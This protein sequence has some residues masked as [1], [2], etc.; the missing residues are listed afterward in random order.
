MAE[1][2]PARR[3]G[4]PVWSGARRLREPDLDE[5]ELV[6]MVPRIDV[7]GVVVE[8]AGGITRMWLK[9]GDV[10]V[11]SVFSLPR[12]GFCLRVLLF[13]SLGL[14]PRAPGI[15]SGGRESRWKGD[16][17]TCTL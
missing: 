15:S 1:P 2:L 13:S 4:D 5:L 17:S 9:L 10:F 3:A 14:M 6:A 16:A 11:F 8:A 7:E 12:Y